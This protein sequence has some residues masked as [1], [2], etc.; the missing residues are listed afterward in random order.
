MQ[1]SHSYVSEL[2]ELILGTL[3]PVY[4]KYY[5]DKKIPLPVKDIPETLLTRIKRKPSVSA[6]LR[7]YEK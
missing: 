3:L 7:P 6:L 2:E 1:F 4:T 5:T